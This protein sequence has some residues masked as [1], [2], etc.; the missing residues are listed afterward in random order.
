MYSRAYPLSHYTSHNFLCFTQLYRFMYSW[1]FFQKKNAAKK[2]F[3]L[4]ENLGTNKNFEMK[5][6]RCH[7]T[8]AVQIHKIFDELE[9]S[10]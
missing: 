7:K 6:D 9:N 2:Q 4:S 1:A 10:A 5:N 8:F 3:L